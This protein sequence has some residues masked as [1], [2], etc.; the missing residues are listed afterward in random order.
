MNQIVLKKK[1]NY[2]K[3]AVDPGSFKDEKILEFEQE[4]E[5]LKKNI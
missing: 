1:L 5:D 2:V 3:E 4:K